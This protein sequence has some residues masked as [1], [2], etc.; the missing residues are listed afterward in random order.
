M[1]FVKQITIV[2]KYHGKKCKIALSKNFIVKKCIPAQILSRSLNLAKLTSICKNPFW[3]VFHESLPKSI[4]GGRK[5]HP[6]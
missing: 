6:D 1:N 5:K 2:R 3:N 4:F